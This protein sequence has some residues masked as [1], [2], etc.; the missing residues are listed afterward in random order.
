MYNVICY[1][2]DKIMR[3]R[4]IP[5]TAMELELYDIPGSG[6]AARAIGTA[7]K[8]ATIAIKNLGFSRKTSDQILTQVYRTYID[9]V[10]SKY[11]EYGARDTEPRSIVIEYLEYIIREYTDNRIAKRITGG[12]EEVVMDGLSY[13][14]Y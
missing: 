9:P 14:I 7:L 10:L 5:S 12:H 3:S 11:A 4:D 6:R 13:V 1:R 2:K 8:K